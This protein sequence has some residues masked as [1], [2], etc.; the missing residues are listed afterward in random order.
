MLAMGSLTTL[1]V[2]AQAL[3]AELMGQPVPAHAQTTVGAV[4]RDVTDQ[5]T[6]MLNSSPAIL[7]VAPEPSQT[8]T[9]AATDE[10]PVAAHTSDAGVRSKPILIGS[11][12]PC[13]AHTW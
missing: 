7:G 13:L 11:A 9:P 1:E 6:S 12:S 5:A 4:L 10:P 3:I 8:P 2:L